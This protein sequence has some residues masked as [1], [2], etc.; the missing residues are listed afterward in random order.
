MTKKKPWEILKS[1]KTQC[2]TLRL[3]ATFRGIHNSGI[4]RKNPGARKHNLNSRT[5]PS[6]DVDFAFNNVDWFRS[7]CYIIK[8]PKTTATSRTTQFTLGPTSLKVRIL[9]RCIGPRH[10]VQPHQLHQLSTEVNCHHR[11]WKC[12]KLL[13][14]PLQNLLEK[15]ILLSYEAAVP[16]ANICIFYILDWD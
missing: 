15:M 11:C 6:F 3:G 8:S 16:I 14:N 12:W 13:D 5:R 4:I 1:L 9:E 7:S 2:L 10:I